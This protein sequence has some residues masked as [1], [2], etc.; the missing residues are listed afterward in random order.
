LSSAAAPETFPQAH[1]Y[2]HQPRSSAP[3]SRR[4]DGWSV[5]PAGWCAILPSRTVPS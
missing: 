3:R 5:K 4:R 2:H 1:P